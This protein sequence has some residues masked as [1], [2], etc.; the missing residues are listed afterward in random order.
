M[1]ICLVSDPYFIAAPALVIKGHW[2]T[3][4]MLLFIFDVYN[5]TMNYNI[6][7]FDYSQ[8][9]EKHKKTPNMYLTIIKV[10]MNIKQQTFE[11]RKKDTLTIKYE[12]HIYCDH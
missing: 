8:Y 1:Y 6:V 12:N 7:K 11:I 2:K 5:D 10:T 9:N 4:G 3:N